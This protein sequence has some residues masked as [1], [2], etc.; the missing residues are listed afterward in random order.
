VERGNDLFREDLGC[1]KDFNPQDIPCIAELDSDSWLHFDRASNLSLLTE[2]IKDVSP[3][4]VSGLGFCSRI[5]L[6][7][8]ISL[9]TSRSLS[10]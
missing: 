1:S 2:K 6:P 10:G 3:H 4:I 5:H 7:F 9:S 8:L